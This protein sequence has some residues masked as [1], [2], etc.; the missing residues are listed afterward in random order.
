V[1]IEIHDIVQIAWTCP[2]TERPYF[3]TER[4]LISIAIDL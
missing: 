4:F 1:A 3:F 2:L